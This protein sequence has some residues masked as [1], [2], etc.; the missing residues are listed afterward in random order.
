MSP[1][2]TEG[3]DKK[4]EKKKKNEVYLEKSNQWGPQD[5][6]KKATLRC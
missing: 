3:G 5:S 4:G 2:P 1:I 6:E